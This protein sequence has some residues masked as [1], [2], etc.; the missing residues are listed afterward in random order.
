MVLLSQPVSS[1]F[2]SVS[3]Y[4]MK[5]SF[6]HLALCISLSVSANALA[7]FGPIPDGDFESPAGAAGAWVP[8][9]GGGTYNYSYP[10]TGGNPGG[11][12]VIAHTAGGGFGIWVG[13]GGNPI[14]LSSLGLQAGKAYT[15]QQDMKLLAGTKIGGFKVD[16]FTGTVNI[17][18]TGDMFPASGTTSWATYSF[19]LTIKLGTDGIKVV[20]LWGA[21]SSVA[22]DNIRIKEPA[23][24]VAT[25]KGG[26]L[27][28]WLGTNGNTYQPQESANG[29]AWVNLGPVIV[30][31]TAQSVLDPTPAPFYQVVEV[32][33]GSADSILPNGGFEVPEGN[34]VGAAN[35]AI[36]V[37]PNAGASMAVAPSYG[38]VLPHGGNTL[39]KME[40]T[41]PLTGPVAAPNTDVRTV[42]FPVDAGVTYDLSFYAA[43]PVKIGGANP[44]YNIFFYNDVSAVVG[45]PIFTSF[46][47]I[48]ANWTKVSTTVTPPAGA[49]K[50]TIGWIQAMG[51]A[52]AWQWVTLIDDVALTTGPVGPDVSSVLPASAGDAVQVTWN[53]VTG[54]N[55]QFQSS[56]NLRTW[57]DL[58]NPV[59]GA[60][61][62]LSGSD[63]RDGPEKFYR[64]KIVP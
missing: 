3:I 14:S 25:I 1:S 7:A 55:Y 29:V 27:V 6:L 41:T 35:W 45:G 16:F 26:A 38:T 48:G 33:P 5:M 30:G 43:H 51:A 31:A 23:P 20:P 64:A 34:S 49:T 36:A 62:P 9:N 63:F 50:L 37:Q 44:Q 46:A 52:N 24:F 13:N 54:T 11:Y 61:N 28:N 4:R 32:I 10:A 39:L 15:F 17:G 21:N 57:M 56:I 60:G 47:S 42:P 8:V 58:G 18:S 53:T 22:Y 2:A 40:S 12:G 59:Q 19:P